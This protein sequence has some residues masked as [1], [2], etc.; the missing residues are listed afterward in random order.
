[1]SKFIECKCGSTT[2]VRM[3][4]VYNEL[5]QVMEDDNGKWTVKE[6]GKEKDHLVGY[7]CSS[8]RQDMDQLN[9][10]L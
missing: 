9:D 8:C 10:G 3:Y 1:M 2:F 7:I 6:W 4:N 5:I